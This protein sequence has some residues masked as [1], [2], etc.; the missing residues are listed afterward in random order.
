MQVTGRRTAVGEVTWDEIHPGSES[1]FAAAGMREVSRPGKRRLVM[2]IDFDG[3]LSNPSTSTEE[4][5][6]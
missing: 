3:T 4:R 6:G 2:R 5:H 1:I